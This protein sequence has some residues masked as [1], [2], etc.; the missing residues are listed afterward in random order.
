VV[1]N[2]GEGF[3]CVRVDSEAQVG[4]L[5]GEVGGVRGPSRLGGAGVSLDSEAQA[6]R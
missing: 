4:G 1:L 5:K 2:V 6:C 3:M